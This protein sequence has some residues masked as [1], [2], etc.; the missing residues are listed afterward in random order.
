LAF[1]N[2]SDPWLDPVEMTS[3]RLVLEPLL[4]GHATEM[5]ALLD[6]PLLHTYVGGEP[7]TLDE[8]TATYTRQVVGR[9]AD[10]SECWLNWIVRRRD[11]G[12][13]AGYVQ[14]TVTEDGSRRSADVAWVIGRAHQ[15]LGFA[16]EAAGTMV[17]WLRS[18]GVDKVVAHVHPD[19]L[20]SLAVAR[21]VGLRPTD[22]VVDGE[23][24]WEG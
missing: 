12:R 13:A 5:A 23:I 1:V 6:D 19:N 11:D 17:A 15:G 20:A 21:T 4:V 24:R 22:R 3:D 8:L 2:P 16:S 10:G 18:E 14:A 7:A 9:S